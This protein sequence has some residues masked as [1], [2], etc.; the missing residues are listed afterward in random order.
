M[1]TRLQK[2]Q[3]ERLKIIQDRINQYDMRFPV[4][5]IHEKL[6]TDMGNISNM[7]KGKKPISDNFFTSFNAAFPEK[8][9]TNKR[10]EPIKSKGSFTLE[11]YIEDLKQDKYTLQEIIK[12]NLTGVMQLLNSRSRHDQALHETIL[13]SLSRLEGGNKDLVLEA[14]SYEAEMQI[15]DSLQG[16]TLKSGT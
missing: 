5:E 16:S 13:R 1:A 3:E 12:V 11:D 7:L 4:A 10:S 15:Q 8:D 6:S 2:S 14:H 9:S